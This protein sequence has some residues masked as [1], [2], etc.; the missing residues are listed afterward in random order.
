MTMYGFVRGFARVVAKIGYRAEFYGTENEPAEDGVIVFSNHSSLVDPFFTAC[1]VNR[2]LH[3][4]A[5]SDLEKLPFIKWLF[6]KCNV[7]AINRGESD[8]AALRK[9]CDVVAKGGCVGIYPQGT[10][11][12]CESPD[13]ETALAGMGLMASRAKAA[14]LPV[15]ICYGKGKKKPKLF[16]K[17]RV[18][19]GTPITFDEYSTINERP[20]SHEIAKYAFS[21]LCEDF[22]KYNN[23]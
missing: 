15:T 17:V 6:K 14:L 16:S 1:A 11:I 20:N 9:V 12:E 21:K 10:R 7:V 18:Y 19:V 2:P 23:D 22:E 13:P 4:M 5:K 3:F 8:I